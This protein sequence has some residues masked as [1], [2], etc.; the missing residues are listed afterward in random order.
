M[1]KIAKSLDPE[2]HAQTVAPTRV[3]EICLRDGVPL[4]QF[5]TGQEFAQLGSPKFANFAYSGS[6]IIQGTGTTNMYFNKDSQT[7]A[8]YAANIAITQGIAS[9]GGHTD[10]FN[11]RQGAT[12]MSLTAPI[13][14]LANQNTTGSIIP[15]VQWPGDAVNNTNGERDLSQLTTT[16]DYLNLFTTPTLAITNQTEL[17]TILNA[18]SSLSLKQAALLQD[19]LVSAQTQASSIAGAAG[20][21]Q[22]LPSR[23]TDTGDLAYG[24]SS[25]TTVNHP[26]DCCSTMNAPYPPVRQA[27]GLSLLGMQ[28]NLINSALVT[29]DVGDWHPLQTAGAVG[30]I[31][32]AISQ[33]ISDAIAFLQSTPEPV[34]TS[35]QTLWDTTSIVVTSEFNRGITQFNVDNS[36]G[37][38]QGVMLIGKNVKGNYYGS[39]NLAGSGDGVAYGINPT[40]GASQIGTANNTTEQ[41]YYTILKLLG[42]ATSPGAQQNAMSAMLKT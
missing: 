21:F 13:V 9:D 34:G 42:L 7:L 5:A 4:I 30:P 12:T 6:Q 36:D 15:G 31:T 3:I 19:K 24:L 1:Q 14:L 26:D 32:Q 10:K 37:G 16:Q 27:M 29:I 38:T 20:L 33:T 17:N 22:P 2:A 8:Q 41:G 28:Y 11:I 23:A 35:G 18:A 25:T 39:F 40:T